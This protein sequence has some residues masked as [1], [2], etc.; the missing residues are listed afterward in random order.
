MLRNSLLL[1]SKKWRNICKNTFTS[2]KNAVITKEKTISQLSERTTRF[3]QKLRKS[4]KMPE[5]RKHSRSKHSWRKC[6]RKI[7]TKSRK[8]ENSMRKSISS[9]LLTVKKRVRWWINTLRDCKR[10]KKDMMNT[11]DSSTP[12]VTNGTKNWKKDKPKSR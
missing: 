5:S 4:T 8:S 3:E 11:S 9:G 2:I 7:K 6:T 12:N 1:N 10:G